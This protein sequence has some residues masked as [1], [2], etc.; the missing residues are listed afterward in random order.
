MKKY[1]TE[2]ILI[3][4][5]IFVNNNPGFF[6]NTMAGIVKIFGSWV[7]IGFRQRVAGSNV[8]LYE[9]IAH[10]KTGFFL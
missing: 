9:R 2:M 10:Q 7:R 6:R 8:Q 4:F 1:K 3:N 5:S